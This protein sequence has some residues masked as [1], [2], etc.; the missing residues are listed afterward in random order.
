LGH[1]C[2][3][4]NHELGSESCITKNKKLFAA[5]LVKLHTGE[6]AKILHLTHIGQFLKLQTSA[7]AELKLIVFEHSLIKVTFY[8]CSL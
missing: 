5:G 6:F 2:C 4:K 3:Q 1:H 7:K 8:W